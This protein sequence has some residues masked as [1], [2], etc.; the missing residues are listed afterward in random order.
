MQYVDSARR[1]VTLLACVKSKN[2]GGKPPDKK[3]YFLG[4]QEP[5]ASSNEEQ[6]NLFTLNDL[7]RTEPYRLNISLYNTEV[8]TELDTGAALTV[9]NESTYNHIKNDSAVPMPLRSVQ[10]KLRS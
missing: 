7:H 2:Q 8:E 1:E 6:Y 10:Q 4:E 3:T 5:P 9:L